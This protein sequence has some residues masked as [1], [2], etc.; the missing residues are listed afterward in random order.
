[1]ATILLLGASGFLG[2]AI[3]NVLTL[4]GGHMVISP[5]HSG[6][7]LQVGADAEIDWADIFSNGPFNAVINCVGSHDD[8]LVSKMVDAQWNRVIDTN[9]TGT[10]RLIRALDGHLATPARIVLLGSAARGVPRA[11]NYVASKAG[12]VGLVGS[13]AAE[14][15]PNVAINVVNPGFIDS[16]MVDALPEHVTA[17]VLSN[18]PMRRLGTAA[19]VAALVTWLALDAPLFLTGQAIN[20]DGGWKL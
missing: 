12:L 20:I 11:A 3:K 9:L 16:P 15:A 13:L 5:T 18:T 19:E 17:K 14:M 6:M 2:N 10:F 8:A 1:M 7:D 4:H